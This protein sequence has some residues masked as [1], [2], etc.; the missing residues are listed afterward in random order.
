MI[1]RV[2]STLL[3]VAF[4]LVAFLFASVLLFFVLV[5]GVVLGG[6]IWWRGRSRLATPRGGRVIDGESRVVHDQNYHLRP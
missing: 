6:W 1:Q 4:L 5:A 2:V 3:G